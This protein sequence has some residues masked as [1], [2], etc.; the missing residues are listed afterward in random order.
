MGPLPVEVTALLAPV[1]REA[2]GDPFPRDGRGTGTLLGR[3]IRREPAIAF[4]ASHEPDLFWDF[5]E[6]STHGFPL[7][8]EVHAGQEDDH[9]RSSR[10]CAVSGQKYPPFAP[11]RLDDHVVRPSPGIDGVAA[12]ESQVPGESPDHLVGQESGRAHNHR[13]DEG[14][15]RSTVGPSLLYRRPLPGAERACRD[16]S[17]RTE[18]G[19]SSA[20]R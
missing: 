2:L 20:R 8:G 1:K 16:C 14:D 9:R 15:L 10:E 18:S 4:R 5:G 13:R 6:R 19:R 17:V 11:R 3:A 7:V 12:N